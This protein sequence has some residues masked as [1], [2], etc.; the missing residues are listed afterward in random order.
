MSK[1][2]FHIQ[3]QSSFVLAGKN[4]DRKVVGT[5]FDQNPS[6]TKKIHLYYNYLK[7]NI[8]EW[9]RK[10]IFGPSQKLTVDI[11]IYLHK[12]GYIKPY[13][14]TVSLSC[15]NYTKQ[16]EHQQSNQQCMINFKQQKWIWCQAGK[17]WKDLGKT[18]DVTEMAKYFNNKVIESLY[19]CA[20]W[21]NIKIQKNYK[22]VPL[23]K[24]RNWPKKEM[25]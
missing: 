1:V 5:H 2:T 11:K 6:S 7:F 15:S 25:S 24:Q 22:S 12:K 14:L 10:S 18:E 19:E 20:R 4:I 13:E 8:S 21:E 17:E 23:I 3:G 16:R 9:H